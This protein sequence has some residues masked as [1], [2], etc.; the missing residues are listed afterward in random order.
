MERKRLSDGMLT[1]SEKRLPRR[2]RIRSGGQ[3]GADRAALDAALLIGLPYEGW[4]PKGGWAEDFPKPP[5]LLT[6]Y[7][8]LVETPSAFPG[9]RT[10]WN[11]R[12]SA[13]TLVLAPDSNY[14]SSGTDFTIECARKYSKPCS[15]VHYLDDDAAVA[16]RSAMSRLQENQSLNVAG[17]R[18][19][20]HPG[21]YDR[22]LAVLVEALG[23]LTG[24]C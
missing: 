3:S 20:E 11:V 13:A 1:A 15:I 22:C 12:D 18:E 5:G 21:A 4:C 19:S 9:Q 7:P 24:A 16:V 6:K 10:E 8:L 23:F 2:P 17:P 14:R